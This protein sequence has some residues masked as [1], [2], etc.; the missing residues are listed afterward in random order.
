MNTRRPRS[1]RRRAARGQAIVLIA[2][3]M[4]VLLGFVA[5]AVD[6]GNFYNQRRVAQNA[7]D[8]SSLAGLHYFYSP[9]P[10]IPRPPS[11]GLVLTEMIRVAGINGIPTPANSLHAYWLDAAGNYVNAQ[12]G[13][14]F[15]GSANGPVQ[16]LAEITSTTAYSKPGIAVGIRV[17]VGFQ[18]PTFIGGIVGTKNVAVQA[19]GVALQITVPW[20][21][22]TIDYSQMSAW[23]GGGNC[24][25]DPTLMIASQNNSNSFDFGGN[26]YINGSGA[27]GTGNSNQGLYSNNPDG[28]PTA[29]FSGSQDYDPGGGNI[30]PGWVNPYGESQSFPDFFYY[31]SASS[32]RHL[33]QAEDF[34]PSQ[35]ATYTQNYIYRDY[36]TI[37]NPPNYFHAVV[38]D[39]PGLTD[40]ERYARTRANGAETNGELLRLAMLS[41][42]PGIYFVDGDVKVDSFW[43]GDEKTVVATGS[44]SFYAGTAS[45]P[46]GHATSGWAMGLS[47]L[48]GGS[49]P[50]G[51]SACAVDPS[52]PRYVPIF[53]RLGQEASW[54]GII[55]VPNGLAA[56]NGNWNG[57]HALGPVMANALSAGDGLN[58]NSLNFGTCSDCWNHPPTY[59]YNLQQ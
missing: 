41:G 36:L 42:G 19:D 58:S 50:A 38:E 52:D 51:S 48:A 14:V 22:D 35:D 2:L 26:A 29:Y 12:T 31:Q 30:S 49:P 46:V 59:N 21:D 44:V 20:N 28:D 33:V 16:P 54:A 34:R 43:T 32:P 55:Y 57:G 9:P 15:A 8:V 11:N 24:G 4:V 45:H 39:T 7:A 40:S 5:L 13:A 47:V 1:L 56:M 27:T 10:A 17:R 23:L 6:G 25:S 53:N 37:Q 3:G 18:Y